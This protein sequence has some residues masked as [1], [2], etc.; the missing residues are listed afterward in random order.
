MDTLIALGVGSAYGYSLPVLYK[1]RG[2]MY[3]EAAAAIITFVLL[4]RYLEERA[5]GKAGEAIRKLVDLQPQKAILLCDG[6]E[7][8]IDIDDIEL[9][10]ILLVRPGEK[11]PTDGKVVFGASTVDESMVTGESMP[12]VKEV[13]HKVIGG[14][15][16]GNGVLHVKV[17]AIGIDTVLAG[18]VRMVDQAQATKLPIQKQVDK[19]SAVLFQPLWAFLLLLSEVGCWLERLLRQHLVVP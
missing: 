19:I 15:V 1:R 3:F 16:N 4:G 13:E 7:T 11:I 18:I 14:C 10:D 17:T 12:V 5:R 2:Y 8:L 9:E 6:K